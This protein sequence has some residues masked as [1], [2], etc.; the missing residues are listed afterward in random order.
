MT[1]AHERDT[2]E[3]LLLQDKSLLF[4]AAAAAGSYSS[5]L[6][7]SHFHDFTLLSAQTVGDECP[8]ETLDFP[9]APPGPPPTARSLRSR[10][11]IG[12][13]WTHGIPTASR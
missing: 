6:P 13:R 10:L 2:Q 3:K 9:S 12:A 8:M 1:L 7:S 11:V 4:H 5:H